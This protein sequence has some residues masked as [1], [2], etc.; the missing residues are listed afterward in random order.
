L[1]QESHLFLNLKPKPHSQSCLFM[2]LVMSE[3]L[4]ALFF[5]LAFCFPNTSLCSETCSVDWPWTQRSA[6]FCLLNPEI[7]NLY[8]PS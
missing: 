2:L 6:W 5:F 8:Y 1:F 4:P 7:K 3:T